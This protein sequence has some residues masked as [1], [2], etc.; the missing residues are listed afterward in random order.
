MKRA[1]NMELRSRDAGHAFSH[2]GDSGSLVA[3]RSSGDIVGIWWG[4]GHPENSWRHITYV[5]PISTV[6]EQ[7]KSNGYDLELV[8]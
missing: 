5:T 2:V 3:Q 1:L 6:L 7:L 8:V 4:G